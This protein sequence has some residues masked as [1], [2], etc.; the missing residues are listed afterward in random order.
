M[1]HEI[2][3]LIQR[4]KQSV[5]VVVTPNFRGQSDDALQ[6]SLTNEEK[7]NKELSQAIASAPESVANDLSTTV[8]VEMALFESG[9]QRQRGRY[10][11]L[12]YNHLK[13]IPPTSVEP[14]RIFSS[15]GIVCNRLRSSLSEKTLDALIFLRSYY[16]SKKR[17]NNKL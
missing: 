17:P 2:V 3:N 7:L 16:S 6:V 14:E 11:S 12:A 8:R 4:T 1:M 5:P 9:G 13:S 15:A 10:L